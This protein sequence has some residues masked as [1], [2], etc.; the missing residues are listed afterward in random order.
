MIKTVLVAEVFKALVSAP[1]S[2]ILKLDETWKQRKIRICT[3]IDPDLFCSFV[4]S[5]GFTRAPTKYNVLNVYHAPIK[6]DDGSDITA[7]FHTALEPDSHMYTR[8]AWAEG[9]TRSLQ[10]TL[11]MIGAI[12]DKPVWVVALELENWIKRGKR[13]L[14]D[15][16]GEAEKFCTCPFNHDLRIKNKAYLRKNKAK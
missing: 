10:N 13:P 11:N 1:L 12:E 16:C 9:Y 6:A 2:T 8:R 7:V 3:K 15:G 14:C 4:E 5:K